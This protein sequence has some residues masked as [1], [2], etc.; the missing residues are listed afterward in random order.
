MVGLGWDPKLSALFI[1]LGTN[2]PTKQESECEAGE[3]HIRQ[4]GEDG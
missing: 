2:Q 3:K 4:C 1:I